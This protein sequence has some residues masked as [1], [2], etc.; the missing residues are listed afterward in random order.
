[1]T[2]SSTRG[3]TRTSTSFLRRAKESSSI[4]RSPNLYRIPYPPLPCAFNPSPFANLQRKGPL[5]GHARLVPHDLSRPLDTQTPFSS[6]LFSR[7]AEILSRTR[8]GHR[9]AVRGGRSPRRR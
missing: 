1:M 4:S 9:G 5:G 3:S 6:D 8:R 2:T 7:G